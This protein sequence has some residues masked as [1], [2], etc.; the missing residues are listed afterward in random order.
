MSSAKR[1]AEW[2]IPFLL[3]SCLTPIA[4]TLNTVMYKRRE[5]TIVLF[6]IL[7]EVI[8]VELCFLWYWLQVCSVQPL[9]FSG[10]C[11]LFQKSAN[12]YHKGMLN[13]IAAFSA[14]VEMTMRSLSFSLFIHCTVDLCMLD[15][16]C[17][18]GWSPLSCNV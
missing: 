5:S 12:F 8:S 18:F 1:V 7:E 6:L 11:H 4:N 15:Q 13:F 16:F 2:P 14:S 10:T 17:S 3:F 9:W